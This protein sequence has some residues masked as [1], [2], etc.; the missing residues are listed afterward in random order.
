MRIAL[1]KDVEKIPGV[2]V[3]GKYT[4]SLGRTGTELSQT[5]GN[6]TYSEVVDTS[7]GQI[8]ASLT[9]Q[10]GK[11]GCHFTTTKSANGATATG[12]WCAD[13][14]TNLYI[15]A[16]PANSAPTPSS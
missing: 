15:S 12:G 6:V 3:A 16:G 5:A 14:N 4:D 1:L 2:T 7:N 11:P 9:L 10:A 13:D 8:L